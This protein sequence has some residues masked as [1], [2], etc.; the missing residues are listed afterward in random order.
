MSF[1]DDKEDESQKTSDFNMSTEL[2][3]MDTHVRMP[4]RKHHDG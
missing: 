3:L 1:V 2:T 4:M